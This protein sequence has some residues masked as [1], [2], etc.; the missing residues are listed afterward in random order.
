[1]ILVGTLHAFKHYVILMNK[2]WMHKETSVSH[3]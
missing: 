3:C 2:S 1:L